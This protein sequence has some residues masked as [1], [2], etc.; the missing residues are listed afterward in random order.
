MTQF[1]LYFLSKPEVKVEYLK[2]IISQQ[3][4]EV[5]SQFLHIVQIVNCQKIFTKKWP[6]LTFTS[7][8]NRKLKFT[9]KQ[10]HI[11]TT[12]RGK[13]TMFALLYRSLILKKIFTKRW[14]QFDLYFLSK[15]EVKVEYLKKIISQQPQEVNSQFFAPLYRS[16]IVK[17]YLQKSDPNLTF[18]SCPNRKSKFNIKT[19]I[20]QQP[21]EVNSQFVHYCTDR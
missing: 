12:A 17:K 15:S 16:L 9:I 10:N 14:P 4:Q 2:K 20:S 18:T 3:P 21:Q 7:C 11:S 5:N 6:N 13:F 19:I 8:P 1:D